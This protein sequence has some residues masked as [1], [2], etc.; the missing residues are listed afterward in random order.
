MN[1]I[2]EYYKLSGLLEC[3]VYHKYKLLKTLEAS[4]LAIESFFIIKELII[5]VPPKFIR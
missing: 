1:P 5:H 2:K 3:I 4:S